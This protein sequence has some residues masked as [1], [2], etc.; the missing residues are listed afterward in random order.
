MVACLLE[1][2]IK[3]TTAPLQPESPTPIRHDSNSL[4]STSP[5]GSITTSTL[6]RRRYP[7]VLVGNRNKSIAIGRGNEA[8]IRIGRRNRQVS[9][10]HACIEYQAQTQVYELH[11][12]GLNG[13]ILDDKVIRQHERVLL[14]DDARI[15]IL[16]TELA[17][18]YPPDQVPPSSSCINANT[19]PIISHSTKTKDT[20]SLPVSTKRKDNM[21]HVHQIIRALVFSRKSSMSPSDICSRILSDRSRRKATKSD[22]SSLQWMERIQTALKSEPFFG[23]IVRK[24]KTADG[25]PKENLYYYNSEVDPVEW[26]RKEYTRVGRSARKCTLQDKQYFWRIPKLARSHQNHTSPNSKARN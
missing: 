3:S 21:D 19:T 23:E 13:A 2:T 5:N 4:S 6:A 16:G 20:P 22:T 15:D 7:I 26:R 9:R 12:V 10:V 24:G 1:G 17:F 11:V 18:I 14:R 8:T 25:S